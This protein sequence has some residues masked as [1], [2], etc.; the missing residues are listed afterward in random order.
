MEREHLDALTAA[1]LLRRQEALQAE[2]HQLI[3][4]LDLFR[5]L[6]HAGKPE[7]IGSSVSGLMVWRDIDFNVLCLGNALNWETIPKRGLAALF[8]FGVPEQGN[9]CCA[10]AQQLAP[11]WEWSPSSP[12]ENEGQVIPRAISQIWIPR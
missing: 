4:Y 2:A 7:Q 5:V 12:A 8:R 11:V 1:E 9:F 3:A 6:F 10:E